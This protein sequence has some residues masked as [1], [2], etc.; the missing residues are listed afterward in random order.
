MGLRQMSVYIFYA[1]KTANGIDSCNGHLSLDSHKKV[2]H[3]GTI[4]LDKEDLKKSIIKTL[5]S[6]GKKTTK[7]IEMKDRLIKVEE[8]KASEDPEEVTDPVNPGE[9]PGEEEVSTEDGSNNN[10]SSPE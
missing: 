8:P 10:S 3:K 7:E 1:R 9:V 4:E 2:G 6:N 5:I